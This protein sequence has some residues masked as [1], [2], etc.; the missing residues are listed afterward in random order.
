M[1]LNLDM[2][3]SA[4]TYILIQFIIKFIVNHRCQHIILQHVRHLGSFKLYF[5]LITYHICFCFYSTL[6]FS[7]DITWKKVKKL[8]YLETENFWRL[9]H[10]MLF[11]LCALATVLFYFGGLIGLNLFGICGFTQLYRVGDQQ[12]YWNIIM[13]TL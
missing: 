1:G 12:V 5:K 10:I 9:L 2:L 4:G 11:L 3:S 8:T 6:S 13:C 7:S